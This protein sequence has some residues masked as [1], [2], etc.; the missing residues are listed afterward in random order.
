MT[1]WLV[2]SSHPENL[3]VCKFPSF[4]YDGCNTMVYVFIYYC[5]F[6]KVKILI[7]C[8]VHLDFLYVNMMTDIIKSGVAW[9]I[10]ATC[11]TSYYLTISLCIS[12]LVK[13]K[14]TSLN[15]DK[16]RKVETWNHSMVVIKVDTTQCAYYKWYYADW[17]VKRNF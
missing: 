3:V 2:F 15:Y 4:R 11:K 7:L 16:Q 13:S 17:L 14:T 6:C 10:S 1:L 5:T 9:P 8:G 12:R